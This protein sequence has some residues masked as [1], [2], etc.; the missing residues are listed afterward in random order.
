MKILI[1]EDDF[2]TKRLLRKT[3]E[4]WGHEV[5]EAGDGEEAWDIFQREKIKFV[6]ADWL[7][8]R[9]D[10]I[11]LC[12]K[13]RS[14]EASGYV[15][16]ILLT[17][18]DKKENIVEGLE[19]GA[20][21]YVV[22]PFERDEL[23]VRVR[24]GERIL[25]L[26]KRLTIKNEKLYRLNLKLE[27]LIRL[28][29]LTELGNRRSFYE[30]ILQIHHQAGRY[31]RCYG[32]VM[33]DLDHFKAYNDTYGHMPGDGV[34]KTVANAIKE[35]LRMSDQVFRFGG[36]EI[37]LLLPDQDLDASTGVAERIRAKIEELGIE[38]RGNSPGIVTISCGVAAFDTDH[39]E[40]RWETVLDLADK[41]LYM[42]KSSG[43]NRVCVYS[44]V[45]RQAE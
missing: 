7:M 18:M 8:P 39:P 38:H 44:P 42:A 35:C 11:D 30:T 3:L 40:E 5:L 9:M 6:I 17:G 32:I 19:T 20:D 1:A 14:S 12:R 13:I 29:P 36:E 41:A 10:G 23:Q 28:D 34:L 2:V 21:D 16:F 26:E 33:C 15:Y 24:T 31:R 37:V 43:R 27:T 4:E 45:S 25:N 22:K